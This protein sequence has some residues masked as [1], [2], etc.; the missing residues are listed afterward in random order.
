MK[1]IRDKIFLLV[2]L[3]ILGISYLAVSRG[4]WKTNVI[5]K[6]KTEKSI[7]FSKNIKI[8]IENSINSN[9]IISNSTEL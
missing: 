4:K 6:G 5:Q 7:F 9:L 8:E 3:T 1:I 2:V